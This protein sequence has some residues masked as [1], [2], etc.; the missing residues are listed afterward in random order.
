[1]TSIPMWVKICGTT[2]LEDAL[3]AAAAGAD[4]L[5]F[6]FAPSPRRIA[7]KDAA[8][9][10]AELPLGVEKIGVFVNQQPAVI[11]Q[12]AAAAGLTGIQLHGDDIAQT[13][14]QVKRRSAG[15][16]KIYGVVSMAGF[17]HDVATADEEI[18]W[19]PASLREFSALLLD[20]GTAEQRGGTGKPFDWDQAVPFVRL[21]AKKISVVIAGGLDPG[22]VGQA[23]ATFHPWGLDVVSGVEREPG[24]KDH[25]KVREFI[26]AAKNSPPRA[27]EKS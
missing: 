24:E 15:R 25:A 7:P 16:L 14:A 5:G 27:S 2:N 19:Q 18:I 23:I 12:T 9:V 13:A 17:A 22:N 21:L 20:S 1:M 4:A 10:I 11:L 8:R 3:A 6:I 26:Q